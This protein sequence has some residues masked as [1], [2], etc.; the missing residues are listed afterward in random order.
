MLAVWLLDRHAASGSIPERALSQ[1]ALDWLCQYTWP[2][3]VRE[4]ENTLVRAATF[5]KGAIIRVADLV[6]PTG[7]LNLRR[8]GAQEQSFETML[9]NRLRPVVRNFPDPEKNE[10]FDL[11]DL[12]VGTAERVILELVM[13][14]TAGNQVRAAALLGLNRN[15]LR[16]KLDSHEIDLDQIRR[17]S[18]R[19]R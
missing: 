15:T 16:R 13:E 7:K 5:A 3:N 14:R 10:R 2:G 6:G 17:R 8:T 12:V 9:V 1:E 18:R 11:H 4:L 19:R